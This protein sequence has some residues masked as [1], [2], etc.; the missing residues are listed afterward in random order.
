[1]RRSRAL[2]LGIVALAVASVPAA[3]QAAAAS[4]EGRVIDG[5]RQAAVAWLEVL[6]PELAEQAT[7]PLDHEERKRWSNLPAMGFP[8]EGVSFGE[9]TPEQR[10]LAHRLIQSPLSS[11][12]YLEV[13]G[14]MHVDE[15][16]KEAMLARRPGGDSPFGHDLYW[17]GVFGD[18][19]A[20][21]AWGLQL[22]GHHLALNFTVVGDGVA[23]TPAFLG[24]EPAEVRDGTY[25]GFSVLG[26]QD[27]L[28]RALFASLD[29]GQRAKAILPGETPRDVIAGPGRG[30]RLKVI[31]GLPA[32]AMSAQQRR[33]L[34]DLVVEYV[35]NLAPEL[36]RTQME[37]I[38]T[39]GVDGLHFAW[40]GT[41]EGKPYYYRVHGPTVLVEF[42]NSYPPGRGSG[43]INHIHSVWRDNEN[44]YGEDLLREHYLESPHHQDERPSG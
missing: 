12:G 28:G 36:A 21:A 3:G 27:A 40:S 5:M 18:P 35:H 42:D 34:L 14:I 31:M 8:R 11:Q 15:L 19:A 33:L 25:A 20:D 44:D 4:G 39:A 17:I 32:S 29:E 37:R 23:V 16:L 26:Q 41:E 1:M 7:F 2:A 43:P 13:A 9:M 6:G 10:I 22:D 30:D 24:A 38:E